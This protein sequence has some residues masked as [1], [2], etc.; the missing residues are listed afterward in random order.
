MVDL[1]FAVILVASLK[2]LPEEVL[3]S[4]KRPKP[5]ISSSMAALFRLGPKLSVDLGAIEYWKYL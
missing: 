2:Y 4:V 1:R 5:R 3:S